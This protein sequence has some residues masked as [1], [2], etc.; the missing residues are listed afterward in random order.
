[1]RL[2]DVATGITRRV[3]QTNPSALAFTGTA[4]F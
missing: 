4:N 2:R 1:M 3:L